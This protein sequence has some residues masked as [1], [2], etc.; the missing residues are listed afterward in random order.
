MFVMDPSNIFHLNRMFCQIY[1]K[2]EATCRKKERED[3]ALCCSFVS[4]IGEI[5]KKLLKLYKH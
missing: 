2:R 5:L 3:H 1:C 4:D